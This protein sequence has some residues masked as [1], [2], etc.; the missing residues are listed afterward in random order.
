VTPD[1][2]PELTKLARNRAE[3]WGCTVAEARARLLAEAEQDRVFRTE[4]VA[5]VSSLELAREGTLSADYYVHRLPGETAPEFR[6]RRQA[7]DAMRRAEGHERHAA[8]L[9]EEAAD[10]LGVDPHTVEAVSDYQRGRADMLAELARMDPHQRAELLS[11]KRHPSGGD[12][13]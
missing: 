6:R 3:Q 10:L 7:E 9:R 8:R 4:T 13:P 1:D 5:I 2:D 12:P 11:R